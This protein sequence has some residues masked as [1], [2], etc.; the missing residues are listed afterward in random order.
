MKKYKT[1]ALA[2]VVLVIVFNVF[3][4]FRVKSNLR[5]EEIAKCSEKFRLTNPDISLKVADKYCSCALESL[6][7]KYK[8]SNIGAEKILENEQLIMKDCFINAKK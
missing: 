2:I 4:Y 1:I 3:D 7:E 8:N 5:N 6:G